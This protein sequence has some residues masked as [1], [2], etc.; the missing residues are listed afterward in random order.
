MNRYLGVTM[1]VSRQLGRVL[2]GRWPE[3][4]RLLDVGAGGADILATLGRRW[5]RRGGRFEGAALDLGRATSRIAAA[6]FTAD[7]GK[8]CVRAICGDARA[9]P[10]PDVRFD[11][12]ICSTFLHH[13]EEDDA[14]HAL[15]EMA[16]VSAL[17]MV[18]TDLRR[19]RPGLLAARMLANTLWRRHRYTRHDAPA[20]MRA[21][22]TMA[23]VRQLAERAGLSV[24][25]EPQLWFRWALRWRRPR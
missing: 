21:A 24:T 10:F 18:V 5:A 16:R 4:L 9:L 19:G 3:R 13:L 20:S 17:G 22:Y 14:V 1:G 7:D 12:T 11:V 2:E 15:R 25:V 8:L 23:E 6:E